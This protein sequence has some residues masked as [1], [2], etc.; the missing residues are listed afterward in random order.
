[1]PAVEFRALGPL[2]VVV[3]GQNLPLR[4]SKHRVVL[5]S[6]LMADRHR[7][8]M[9]ALIEAVWADNPPATAEKQIRNTVSDLRRLL[10]T[11][12]ASVAAVAGGY[13]LDHA[14][15]ELDLESF[16]RDV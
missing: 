6:L 7:V 15:G 11:S 12:G 2:E 8:S 16:E 4:G 14:G 3:D 13:Q 9:D 10:S 5:A 1:M